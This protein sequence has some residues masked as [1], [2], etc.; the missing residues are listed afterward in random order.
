MCGS[1]AVVTDSAY[2]VNDLPIRQAEDLSKRNL[3]RWPHLSDLV[4]PVLPDKSVGLLIGCDVPE[5]HSILEQRIGVGKQPYAVR[6]ALGWLIR[7]P[8]G[9]KATNTKCV[10]Y[11]GVE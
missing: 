7:G 9:G 5:A 4:I 3:Q 6:S 10:N 1:D 8:C 11:L 2:T